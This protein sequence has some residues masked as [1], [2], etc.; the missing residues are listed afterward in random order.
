MV[1]YPAM[2]HVCIFFQ[3]GYFWEISEGCDR[4]PLRN[5]IFEKN[6]KN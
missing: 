2:T 5:D 4:P 6:G 3:N 1:T